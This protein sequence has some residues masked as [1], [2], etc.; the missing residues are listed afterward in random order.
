MIINHVK[1]KGTIMTDK[2]FLLQ[3]AQLMLLALT[4][5][6]LLYLAAVLQGGAA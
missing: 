1:K 2:E 6:A 4:G 5:C 3:L